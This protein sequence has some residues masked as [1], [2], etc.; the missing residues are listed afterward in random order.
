MNEN[1]IIFHKN[2]QWNRC[3][4]NFCESIKKKCEKKLS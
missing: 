4:R 2:A 3:L 1:I